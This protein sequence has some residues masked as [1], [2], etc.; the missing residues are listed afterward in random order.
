[1]RYWFFFLFFLIGVG[2]NSQKLSCTPQDQQLFQE[3]LK[4]LDTLKATS[5]ADSLV[6]V[7]RSFLGTPYAE[8]T[9][10]IGK[11]ETLVINLRGLDCTTF[12]ENVLAFTLSL[13]HGNTSLEGFAENL[14]TI[15]YRNGVLDGYPSR[16]HY[17][18]DWIRNNEQKGLVKSITQELQGKA[19][20]KEINFMGTHR[21]LY[22]FLKDDSNFERILEME[23]SLAKETFWYIPKAE[24]A[25]Q[26]TNMLPGDIIALATNIK[27]LD[28]THTGF[29][30]CGPQNRIHLLH[31]STSGEVVISKKPLTEYLKNIKHNIGILVARPSF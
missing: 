23:A 21:E 5:F 11:T 6:T 19:L 7:G 3:K 20:E 9:L 12:V 1:M 13:K 8:K 18:T 31:A 25:A 2:L 15:R 26:E 17:F 22:P 4:V 24:I 14:K 30:V 16:L 27:G 28:V 29:A 10:E